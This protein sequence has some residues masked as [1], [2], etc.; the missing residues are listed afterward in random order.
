[1]MFKKASIRVV[2]QNDLSTTLEM[3]WRKTVSRIA[4][5]IPNPVILSVS[6][7]SIHHAQKHGTRIDVIFLDRIQ[8]KTSSFYYFNMNNG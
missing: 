7:G 6:K 8:V 1:M 3:T 4:F 5:L 2:F